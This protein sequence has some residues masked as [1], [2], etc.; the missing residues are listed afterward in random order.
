MSTEKRRFVLEAIDSETDC[1]VAKAHFCVNDVRELCAIVDPAEEDIKYDYDLITDDAVEVVRRY[2]PEFD[3]R[4]LTVRLRRWA[5]PDDLPYQ[6]HTGYE[7]AMMLEGVKPLAVFDFPSNWEFAER[8][9]FEP[10]VAS[11]KFVVREFDVP[12]LLRTRGDSRDLIYTHVLYARASEEWRIDAYIFLFLATFEQGWTVH[13]V[14]WLQGALL[15]YENWQ[16]ELH[17]N[18][19]KADRGGSR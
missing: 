13:A 16:N 1:P 18:A 4:G 8:A 6:V 7:L 11:G 17:I 2:A 3:S 5:P 14:E 15:G 19:R 12:L 10:H 9:Y